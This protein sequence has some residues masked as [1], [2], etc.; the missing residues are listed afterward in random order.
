MRIFLRCDWKLSVGCIQILT[1][2]FSSPAGFW[3]FVTRVL[4]GY[5]V[6]LTSI[7]H[8]SWS[9]ISFNWIIQDFIFIFYLFV[10][11]LMDKRS[12]ILKLVLDCGWNLYKGSIKIGHMDFISVHDCGRLCWGFWFCG[13][14][15]YFQSIDC[16]QDHIN[17]IQF[18]VVLISFKNWS[19]KYYFNKKFHISYGLD[20]QVSKNG[21]HKE[22][23]F[24]HWS[25]K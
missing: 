14:T 1:Y 20:F 19:S 10:L 25:S 23:Y 18:I 22:K 13:F 6:L 8:F 3:K 24:S 2:V 7:Y 11:N 16:I 15:C 9:E 17:S 12:L 5:T 21:R 4:V